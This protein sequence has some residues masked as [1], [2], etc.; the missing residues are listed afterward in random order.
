MK[1]ITLT[2]EGMH[3]EGCAQ[4]IKTLVS[5]EPG[6][7]AATV[8]FKEGEARVLYDPQATNEDRVIGAIEKPG[9]R[10]VGRKP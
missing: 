4:T 1:S 7:R 8:S 2:V 9:Y 5:A 3:C 6:V 10:V